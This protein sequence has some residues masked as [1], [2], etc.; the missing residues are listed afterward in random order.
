MNIGGVEIGKDQPTRIVAEISNSHNGSFE[1]ARRLV[2]E[3]IEAGADFIKFQCYTPEELVA[4]RGGGLAPNPWGAAGWTMKRLYER[5]QTPH[6]WFP[7]LIQECDVGDTPWFSSV[8]GM[9]SLK[10]LQYYGCPAY[11]V[12]ALDTNTQ[13]VADLRMRVAEPVIASNRK[14]GRF[15]WAE[16]TLYCPPGYPQQWGRYSA[17]GLD[18][19]SYHGT[20]LEAACALAGASRLFECHVQLDDEP[21]ELEADVC[22]TVSQ[23]SALCAARVAA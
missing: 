3:C 20:S 21:S 10:M 1:T 15:E 19:V 4:L 11:K 18:G 14:R 9:Q 13:F 17:E 23:L 7:A 16:L 5:A 8:F 22:L 12:A 2:Y 6:T